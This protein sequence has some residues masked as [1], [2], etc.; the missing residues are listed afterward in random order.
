MDIRSY[1]REQWDKQVEYG[2]PWTLPVSP[3]AVAAARRGEWSI[4]T[5]P[6]A[7]NKIYREFAA[8]MQKSGGELLFMGSSVEGLY[9]VKAIMH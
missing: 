1:N 8:T 4:V 6:N 5:D 7:M 9:G 2:N 3:E